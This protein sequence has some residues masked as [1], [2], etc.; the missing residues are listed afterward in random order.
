MRPVHLYTRIVDN[1]TITLTLLG[2]EVAVDEATITKQ[3]PV[4][5]ESGNLAAFL[6]VFLRNVYTRQG[7]VHR[8]TLAART[9]HDG[10]YEITPGIIQQRG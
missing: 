6:D 3:T 9:L 10:S 5:V 4:Y 7:D 2:N 8:I 1:E